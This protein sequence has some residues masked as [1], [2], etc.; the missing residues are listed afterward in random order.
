MRPTRPLT[1]LVVNPFAVLGG[2]ESWL[3]S[4]LDAQ[5]PV[6]PR[7]KV[8][9]ILLS[10]G[11]LRGEFE[12]RGIAVTVRRTGANGRH[13]AGSVL[14][15]RRQLHNRDPDVVL[16]NGVKAAA[17]A[18][19]AAR[20]AGVPCVWV[21]H[22]HSFD[23]RL[24]RVLGRLSTSVIATVSDVAAAIPR[25]DI[26][27]LEPPRP[28]E[29]LPA[30]AARDQLAAAGALPRAGENLLIMLGRYVPY[31]GIDTAIRALAEPGGRNW[32]LAALGGDEPARPQERQ[33][34]AKLA[35][36]LGVADRVSL[37]GH[38]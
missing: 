10:D 8:E 38:V 31:K 13:I 15:L 1:V 11:P 23:G 21:K 3:L 30:P 34:L 20:L 18:C 26:A 9:A 37:P 33:R 4:V 17:V 7:L 5:D 12:R 27:V 22:D 16:A 25:N 2:A 14:W 24:T 28:G 19:P 32:Q 29:P 36:E 6:A 35:A